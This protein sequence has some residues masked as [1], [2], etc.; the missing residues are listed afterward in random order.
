MPDLL[1][2]ATAAFIGAI[3]KKPGEQLGEAITNQVQK[4]HNLISRRSPEEAEVIKGII[5]NPNSNSEQA[6]MDVV[7]KLAQSDDEIK[8]ALTTLKNTV[9]GQPQTSLQQKIEKLG[10]QYINSTVNIDKQEFN[11]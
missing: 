8:E 11:F 1:T 6:L 9:E 2:S 5:D 7:V 3:F 10:N 4:V